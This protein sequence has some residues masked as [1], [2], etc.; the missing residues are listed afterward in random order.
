[1][2]GINQNFMK[3]QKLMFQKERLKKL[4]N[5]LNLYLNNKDL[6]DKVEIKFNVEKE[7]LLSLMGMKQILVN[8]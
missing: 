8:T 2:I 5:G 3:I 4:K 1:M 7:L 6:I